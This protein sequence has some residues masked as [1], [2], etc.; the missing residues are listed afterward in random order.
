[1]PAKPLPLFERVKEGSIRA[2]SPGSIYAITGLVM[3]ELFAMMGCYASALQI[4]GALENLFRYESHFHSYMPSEVHYLLAHA[5]LLA[6]CVVLAIYIPRRLVRVGRK[7]YRVQVR[8]TEGF[9]TDE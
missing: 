1:M 3:A 9:D 6:L 7:T 5:A 8:A 4:Q 2:I